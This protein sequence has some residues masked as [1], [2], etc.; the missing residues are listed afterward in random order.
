MTY[1]EL[2]KVLVLNL[3]RV[4]VVDP[5]HKVQARVKVQR[6]VLVLGRVAQVH[7]R[8]RVL[9]HVEAVGV[10]SRLGRVAELD[11][12]TS[13]VARNLQRVRG[14]VSEPVTMDICER[15]KAY[16]ERS[17]K[18]RVDLGDAS[19]VAR[20]HVRAIELPAVSRTRAQA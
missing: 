3:L 6:D 11:M 9:L 13:G 19:N 16:D 8:A 5:R 4:L 12:A 1:I 14:G 10:R 2:G 15:E 17:H 20:A 7:G 18:D